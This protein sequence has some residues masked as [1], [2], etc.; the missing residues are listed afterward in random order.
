MGRKME[1]TPLSNQRVKQRLARNLFPDADLDESGWA[2]SAYHFSRCVQTIPPFRDA[3]RAHTF[4]SRVH[5]KQS[6][7]LNRALLLQ[8][9]TYVRIEKA[10]SANPFPANASNVETH[11]RAHCIA[12]G[13]PWWEG[14]WDLE[15][16]DLK[17]FWGCSRLS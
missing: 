11:T 3:K 10:T 17:R 4:N 1:R 12:I 8:N 5:V 7:R 6:Q 15:F 16:G 2:T 14:E 9:T 13:C